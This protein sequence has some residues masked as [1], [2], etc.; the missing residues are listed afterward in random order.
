MAS[1][2]FQTPSWAVYLSAAGARAALFYNT[3]KAGKL[4]VEFER[5][6]TRHL[7]RELRK[8]R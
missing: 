1:Q 3:D 5:N 8:P 4:E 7:S 6:L 2:D